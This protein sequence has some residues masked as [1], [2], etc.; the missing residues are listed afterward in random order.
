MNLPLVSVIIPVFN[1]NDYFEE[2]I[3]SMVNQS[4]ANLE[5]III[6]DFSN[7]GTIETIK[8]W[9][10]LDNRIIP[11]FKNINT[12]IVE[13]LN[14]GLEIA[15]G[16]YIARMDGDDISHLERIEKQVMFLE[17]NQNCDLLGTGYKIIGQNIDVKPITNH[18]LIKIALIINSQ[19]V[20]PSIMF[21]AD[22]I[23]KYKFYYKKEFALAE[24][25]ELWTRFVDKC[26][27]GNLDETL[28]FYRINGPKR[29]DF[30]SRVL[31]SFN[32]L[33]K[34]QNSVLNKEFII[35]L[36]KL[37][38]KSGLYYN[39]QT[40]TEFIKINEFLKKKNNYFSK[41]EFDIFCSLVL[42]MTLDKVGR[43]NILVFNPLFIF[44]II[45][46]LFRGQHLKSKINLFSS[47]YIDS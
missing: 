34:I 27:V 16:K 36:S 2:A 3:F 24:D 37:F 32:H 31:I 9:A 35:F 43:K 17:E 45:R 44:L 15:S 8:Y 6:D 11:I 5:I 14:L 29:R 40:I 46:D 25:Y 39:L 41:V 13:S 4:Y 38:E 20:H 47:I 12:G 23:S 26:K 33:N 42:R 10:G 19:F 28:L 7:D 21:R 30:N 18:E 22:V 1:C